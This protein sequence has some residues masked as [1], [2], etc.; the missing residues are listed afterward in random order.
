M[1]EDLEKAI[2]DLG[3]A[4]D[5]LEEALSKSG[6]SSSLEPF[7]LL[8]RARD[9]RRDTENLLAVVNQAHKEKEGHD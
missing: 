4:C 3:F 9:L 7:R 8:I 2:H 1:K 6:P 5:S